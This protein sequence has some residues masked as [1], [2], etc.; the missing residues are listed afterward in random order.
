MFVEAHILCC[1]QSLNQRWRQL[2]ITN[3][4]TVLAVIVPCTQNL[5]ISRVHLCGI[6]VDRILQF[7]DRRQIANPPFFNGCKTKCRK[8]HCEN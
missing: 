8:Q 7:F 5:S 1:H 6:T 3:H 4:N 2:I